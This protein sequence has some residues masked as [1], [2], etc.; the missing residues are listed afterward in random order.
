MTVRQV[1]LGAG[2]P[3]REKMGRQIAQAITLLFDDSSMRRESITRVL[4][5]SSGNG[6]EADG[7]EATQSRDQGCR[8]GRNTCCKNAAVGNEVIAAPPIFLRCG[9]FRG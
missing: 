7:A 2:G 1:E 8:S 4:E 9:S 6:F 5:R 3:V